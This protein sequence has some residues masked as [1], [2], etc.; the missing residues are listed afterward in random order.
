MK[1][2]IIPFTETLRKHGAELTRRQPET[3]QVNLGRLCNQACIHCHVGAGPQRKEVMERKTIDRI[4]DLL[5][6]ASYIQTV[7]LTGGAPELNPHF[8][9]IVR[10]AAGL[11]KKVIDRCNLTVL[12]ERGQ[13]DT[14]AFLREHRVN[15]LASL[16][17]YLSE[18][19]DTQ[20]GI[21][22]FD[23]SIRGLRLLNKL[24][25]GMKDSGLEL[26]LVYNPLGAFLP[27]GQSGLERDYKEQL[28]T[29][30]EI[31]FNSLFTITNMPINRFLHSLEKSGKLK[32]YMELLVN[33]FNI[34]AA[35]GVMCLSLVSVGWDGKLYDCDFNQMADIP[36]GWPGVSGT[37]NIWEI[38]SFDDIMKERIALADHCYGCTAGGGSSCVGAIIDGEQGN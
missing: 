34:Q 15:V 25:Y 17:C 35:Q 3:L 9:L 14:P 12:F 6:S 10:E 18:N 33:N 24:G 28:K 32:G 7:D 30:F 1:T 36:V 2:N 38:T 13:E 31:E 37:R 8:K 4:L 19:V 27:P 23:K 29:R 16:P 11:G 22:V 21:G 26:H 5:S 20:R